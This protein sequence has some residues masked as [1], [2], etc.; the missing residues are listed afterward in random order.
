MSPLL[1]EAL[2]VTTERTA[3]LGVTMRFPSLL[4]RYVSATIKWC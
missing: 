3:V 1:L 2:M 4:A